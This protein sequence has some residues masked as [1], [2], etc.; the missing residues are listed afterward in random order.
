MSTN[1]GD[2]SGKSSSA[3]GGDTS[4]LDIERMVND[5]VS[6]A[7]GPRMK[8]ATSSMEEMIAARVAEALAKLAPSSPEAPKIEPASSGD[9]ESNKL[10]L[11]TLDHRFK[12]LQDELA[13][14]RKAR[15]DAEQSAAQARLR[16]DLESHF[17]RHMGSDNK[18]L[19]AYLKLYGEQFQHKDGATY[20]VTK[21]EFGEEQ[22]VP[23]AQAVD[24]LFKSDLKDLIPQRGPKLPP[25]SIARGMPMAPQQGQNGQPPQLGIFEREILHHQAMASPEAYAAYQAQLA[26]SDK[27]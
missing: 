19:A 25:T 20:R 10:N 14:E 9:I 24:N 26:N 12:A 22:Y 2:D 8:R 13:A 1:A 7:L 6:K 18:H 5:A 17:A 16:S 3:S 23:V 15:A 4:G 11:K 21:D 27:K